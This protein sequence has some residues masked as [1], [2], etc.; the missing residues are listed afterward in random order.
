MTALAPAGRRAVQPLKMRAPDEPTPLGRIAAYALLMAWALVVLFPLYWLGITSVKVPLD[1]N[2]GPYYLPFIDFQPSLHA[3]DYLFGEMLNDTLRPYVNTV[4]TAL[5]SSVVAVAIGSMAAY[6]LVRITYRPKWGNILAFILCVILAIVAVT[7]LGVPWQ[8]AVALAIAVF[9]L[10]LSTV[11]RRFRRHLNNNDIAFWMVSQRILPPVAVVVPIYVLFQHLGLLDTRTALIFTYVA[12]N[13]PIVV[14]LMRD[15]FHSI[16]LELE[17]VAMIDG[18]TRYRIF[19]SVVLPLSGPGL[20]ATFILVLILAWNE[21]LLALFLSSANAQTMPLLVAAQN[22]T[23]GPQWWYMSVLI[24]VMILPV[25]AFAIVLER[26][27]TRGLLI[28]A[29]KG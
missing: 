21:Y 23:R 15:F 12:V 18:A 29:V 1:V 26:F 3:W 2:D 7:A 27:I 14:W 9:V 5:V 19:W 8:V 22:A 11:G 25:T 16:P 24:I 28:G 20:A 17:E 13:V 10:V 6:A 4:I